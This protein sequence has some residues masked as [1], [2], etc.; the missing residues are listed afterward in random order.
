MFDFTR[1][2]VA[3]PYWEDLAKPNGT[4][5]QQGKQHLDYHLG[6]AF[7]LHAPRYLTINNPDMKAK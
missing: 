6:T 2:L 1:A 7:F 5:R 3:F 4:Y